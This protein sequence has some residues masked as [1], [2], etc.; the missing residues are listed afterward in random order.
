MSYFVIV[1]LSELPYTFQALLH[2]K[3]DM[4]EVLPIEFILF[5]WYLHFEV[6]IH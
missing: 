3:E 5:T 6:C 1:S 4:G 2:V